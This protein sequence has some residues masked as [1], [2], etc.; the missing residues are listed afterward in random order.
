MFNPLNAIDKKCQFPGCF[1]Q[2]PWTARKS[3]LFNLVSAFN[4]FVT[5]ELGLYRLLI[6]PK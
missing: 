1:H 2:F 5:T 6:I 3:Y 4:E